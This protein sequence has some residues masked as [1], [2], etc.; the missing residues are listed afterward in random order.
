[1]TVLDFAD[2]CTLSPQA[3]GPQ[4]FECVYNPSQPWCNYYIHTYMYI[5]EAVMSVEVVEGLPQP[6]A[7]HL[8]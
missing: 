7:G 2:I 4:A 8:K 3:F 5:T 1:M 6:Q